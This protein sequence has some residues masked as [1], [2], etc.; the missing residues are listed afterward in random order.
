MGLA[1]G[2]LEQDWG[3]KQIVTEQIEI[4][5]AD[6]A[7]STLARCW[8]LALAMDLSDNSSHGAASDVDFVFQSSEVGYRKAII[9]QTAGRAADLSLD[10]LAFQKG[11][12]EPGSWDAREF[13]KRVFVPWNSAMGSPLGSAADPYVSNQFRVL[14]FDAAVRS[15][16]KSK[17]VFDATVRI[18]EQANAAQTA[19][20]VEAILVEV[21][22]GLRRFLNNRS[23]EY[24]LPQRSSLDDTLACIS[25]FLGVASGGTRLQAVTLALFQE[26]T[27]FGVGLE[28]L[29][30]GHVNSADAAGGGA[31]DIEFGL[32][33]RQSAIEAKDRPLTFAE[34]EASVEKC[35]I[36]RKDELIFV[37]NRQHDS[38]FQNDEDKT[39]AE[40][41]A[42]RQ[43]SAGLNV[44]FESFS[45]L[46][47][48]VLMLVGEAGRRR[49]FELVSAAL[50]EQK[51]DA[52]HRWAWAE[53][54]REI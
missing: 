32:K 14:R 26:L 4:S 18:L 36:S 39:K 17:D 46:A 25:R 24:P 15:Q 11:I 16:R 9:I 27:E 3:R 47:R 53:C 50:E 2:Q 40:E 48:S 21:L 5:F 13:A 7:S 10:A 51:A 23:Y 30:S 28:D 52:Q 41:L 42:R 22:L 49:F 12:G 8:A 34:V 1:A 31:G 19:K 44:Y 20:E 38:L 54:V 35:R 45:R 37:V 29:R 43:F 33:N 6:K